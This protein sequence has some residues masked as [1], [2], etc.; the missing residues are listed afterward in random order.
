MAQAPAWTTRQALPTG[1]AGSI[2]AC[3]G[4]RWK[5]YRREGMSMTD[6]D[7]ERQQADEQADEGR[8]SVNTGRQPRPHE[9][10]HMFAGQHA[11]Q[12]D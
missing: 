4:R 9:R 11:E 2:L 7:E 12:A 10:D 5:S 8:P 1:P 6:V 3:C